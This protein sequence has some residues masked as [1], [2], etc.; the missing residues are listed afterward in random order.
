MRGSSQSSRAGSA[1]MACP[2]RVRCCSPPESLGDRGVGERGRADL[3]DD[4]VDALA[5]GTAFGSDAPAVSGDALRDHVAGAQRGAR[6]HQP[7]LRDVAD[8]PV[9]ATDRTA[10]ERHRPARQ[11]LLAEDGAEQRGLAGAVRSEDGDELAGLDV[12]V[13][14]VPEPTAA[15][16]EPGVPEREHGGAATALGS[17]GSVRI[18][19]G[20]RHCFSA[21]VT[22]SMFACCHET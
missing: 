10:E 21:A 1:A 12:E 3:V 20:R 4:P 8:P 18:L 19:E 9:A 16:G 14:P 22:A 7:L 5:F 2:T 11:A 6:V 15:V 13:E 17:G